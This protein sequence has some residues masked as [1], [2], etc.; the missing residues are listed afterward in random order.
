MLMP[1]PGSFSI[2]V[3]EAAGIAGI[4]APFNAP[5]ALAIRSLAP[6]LAAG[7]TAVVKLPGLTA[8]TN[9][10][11][12][13]AISETTGLPKGV[14]NI[15]TESGIEGSR[16]LVESPDVP[17]ISFT[18]SSKTGRAIAAAGA[19]QL[20]RFIL[21]L[22]GK[23][24]MVIFDD[25]DLQTAVFTIEKAITIFS[26]Q[27]CMTGSRILVQRGIA[28]K[29]RK[30]LAEGPKGAF[31]R[32]TLLEVTDSRLPIVQEEVFGPVAT[33]QIFDT[34]A[35]AILLANDS[36]YGLAASIWTRDIDRPW[37]VAK[38]IQA[39]T[40]WINTYAQIFPEFEEGGYKQSGTGRLNGEAALEDF[41]EYK[42]ISFNPGIPDAAAAPHVK[43]HPIC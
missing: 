28:E 26:G 43:D 4:I 35:E 30:A 20:K 12:S 27:F 39:G 37:R 16:Y 40:I 32:P 23:T 19:A 18:G 13:K 29:V 1:K 3:R 2:T 17:V 34:E 36:E 11:L 8:Q 6:A 10:M 31:Y 9:A 24:P 7:T 33:F 38:G 41:L 25:A 14:I 15:I 5:I 42:H 21:E 22:G